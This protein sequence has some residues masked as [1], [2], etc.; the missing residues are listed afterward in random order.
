MRGKKRFG[1]TIPVKQNIRFTV[2]DRGKIA[3]RFETHNIFLDLGCEWLSELISYSSFSPL[4]AERNDRVRYMGLGIGANTQIALSTA[5]GGD[6]GTAYPGSNLQTDEDPTVLRLERPVRLSGDVTTYPGTINDEWLGQVQAPAEHPTNH[7]VL[8]RRLFTETEISY[9]PFLIVP[10]SEVMLFTSAA[11][12]LIYNNTGIAY[13]TFP[14][15]SKTNAL[16][17]E[18]EWTLIFSG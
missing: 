5:N 3:R 16:S 13:D 1:A 14:T 6:V 4:T 18:I 8:F 7:S 17:I 11:N 12:P 10:L 15:I 9:T 2:R